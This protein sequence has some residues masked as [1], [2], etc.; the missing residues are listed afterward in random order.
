MPAA[1]GSRRRREL[2]RR[3]QD[4]G[5]LRDVDIAKAQADIA[6]VEEVQ[7]RAVEENVVALSGQ[8]L[9]GVILREDLTIGVHAHP[10]GAM[11]QAGAATARTDVR[12]VVD[13]LDGP[14]RRRVGATGRCVEKERQCHNRRQH[15]ENLQDEFHSEPPWTVTRSRLSLAL[16]L[17]P[18][19]P[20]DQTA[21]IQF[22]FK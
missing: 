1:C 19:R 2:H 18:N 5:A 10:Q 14:G 15:T 13:R 12:V 16:I 3:G 22:G 9:L 8:L 20:A 7:I 11:T 17:H 6:S 4:V 21:A